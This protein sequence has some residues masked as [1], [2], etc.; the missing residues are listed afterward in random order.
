MN[1]PTQIS[2]NDVFLFDE[3]LA[4]LRDQTAMGFR[5]FMHTQE[6]ESSYTELSRIVSEIDHASHVFWS[7]KRASHGE[8]DLDDPLPNGLLTQTTEKLVK[9]LLFG[10]DGVLHSSS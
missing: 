10:Y 1:S 6:Q 2:A 7:P 4:K 5:E 3:E 8:D 9:R